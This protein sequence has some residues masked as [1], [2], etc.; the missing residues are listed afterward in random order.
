LTKPLYYTEKLTYPLAGWIP[1]AGS[2][3]A[4]HRSGFDR[5]RLLINSRK[6]KFTIKITITDRNI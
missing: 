6:T 5:R 3:A 4:W 2:N 1:A